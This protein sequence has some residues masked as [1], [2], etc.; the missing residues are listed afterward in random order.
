MD[1]SSFLQGSSDLGDT[2]TLT[3]AFTSL[4]INHELVRSDCGLQP[5]SNGQL[6]SKEDAGLAVVSI[7][8]CSTIPEEQGS[9]SSLEERK[10]GED[11]AVVTQ[12]SCTTGTQSQET[13]GEQK[14]T[15][16]ANSHAGRNRKNKRKTT[17]TTRR[18]TESLGNN[19]STPEAGKR[20]AR[21]QPTTTGS[22]TEGTL[23]P[24]EPVV[25]SVIG[26]AGATKNRC[27]PGT[28]ETQ[29]PINPVSGPGDDG[30]CVGRK[31][32]ATTI[33]EKQEGEK[34]EVELLV[35]DRVVETE[36]L[37]KTEQGD[38]DSL[39]ANEAKLHYT[40]EPAAG[41]KRKFYCAKRLKQC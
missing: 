33:I 37:T 40:L 24:I 11:S 28:E 5:R 22:R 10:L 1:F 7:E 34:W 41:S 39:S 19:R 26:E 29:L 3:H 31:A 14:G 32:V 4:S 6:E 23:S 35:F 36:T 20:T 27:S 13:G 9:P 12:T 16:A 30:N 17:K 18:A 38:T 21:R 15:P 8:N 25:A 2:I